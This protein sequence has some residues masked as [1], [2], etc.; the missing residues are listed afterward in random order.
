MGRRGYRHRRWSTVR[1]SGCGGSVEC[2]PDST[3]RTGCEDG[4]TQLAAHSPDS[5]PGIVGRRHH[6]AARYSHDLALKMVPAAGLLGANAP[7][8][9]GVAGAEPPALNLAC[10]KLSNPTCFMSRVRPTGSSALGCGRWLFCKM[11]PAAGF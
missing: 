4:A 6:R 5:K 3:G 1:L 11:V 9:Y 8:P 10:A 2:E 7:R